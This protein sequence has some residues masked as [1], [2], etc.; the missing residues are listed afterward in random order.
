[1]AEEAR[2]AAIEKALDAIGWRSLSRDEMAAFVVGAV[3]QAE[4]AGVRDG[5]R[6]AREAAVKAAVDGTGYRASDRMVAA[7]DAL[8]A[9]K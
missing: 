3:S 4:A 7:I 8:G 6:Q 2:E 5:I 1:M 9:E